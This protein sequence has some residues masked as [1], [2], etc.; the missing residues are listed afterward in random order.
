MCDL[1]FSIVS[2]TN[3]VP[4][5]L[6][7]RYSELRHYLGSFS[8]DEYEVSF[9][10]FWLILVESLFY[11]LLIEATSSLLLDPFVWKIFRRLF[12]LR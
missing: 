11:Q 3:V 6:E 2:L 4:L 10:I 12:T 7:D 8:F 1:S 5:H 9:P